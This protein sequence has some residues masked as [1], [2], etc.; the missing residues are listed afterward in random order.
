M[1]QQSFIEKWKLRE[2]SAQK[3]SSKALRFMAKIQQIMVQPVQLNFN[4]VFFWNTFFCWI[5]IL[6]TG[7]S[8]GLLMDISIEGKSSKLMAK[9]QQKFV[10][11]TSRN[12]SFVACNS[13]EKK[14]QP[15]L[16]LF[17]SWTKN[18]LIRHIER[19]NKWNPRLMFDYENQ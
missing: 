12:S 8:L 13:V 4:W 7:S 18:H 19:V 17:Q 11:R 6:K 5:S 1:I 10:K 15:S 9:R 16:H 14:K 2:S 3:C